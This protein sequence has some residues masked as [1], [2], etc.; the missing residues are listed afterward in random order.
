MAGHAPRQSKPYL[1]SLPL[2]AREANCVTGFGDH[3]LECLR[4]FFAAGHL[5]RSDDREGKAHLK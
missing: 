2:C 5:K 1:K 3:Y 4:N